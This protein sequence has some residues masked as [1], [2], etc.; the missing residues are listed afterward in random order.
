MYSKLKHT[1][2]SGSIPYAPGSTSRY[3]PGVL[4]PYAVCAA[5]V[6]LPRA[7]V[8]P[9]VKSPVQ[10][11]HEC[12]HQIEPVRLFVCGERS[13]ASRSALSTARALAAAAQVLMPF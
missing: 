3:K 12:R 13:L 6:F 2:K 9:V 10:R 7:E 11:R 5:I 4:T 1:I 8:S